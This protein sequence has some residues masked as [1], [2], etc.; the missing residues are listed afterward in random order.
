MRG[1]SILQLKRV[2][3]VGGGGGVG[4]CILQ[5]GGGGGGGALHFAGLYAAKHPHNCKGY[6]SSTAQKSLLAVF[7]FSQAFELLNMPLARR[8]IVGNFAP[9]P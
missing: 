4:R 3:W 6:S 1:A 8:A 9:D 5:V 2:G 7:Q